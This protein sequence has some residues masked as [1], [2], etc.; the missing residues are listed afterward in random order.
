MFDDIRQELG[1][2]LENIRGRLKPNAD[3]AG[4]TWFRTGG[5]AQ[6]LFQPEDEE[7]LASFLAVLPPQYPVHVIGLGSNL[8]VRDGGIRGVVV[9][10]GAKGFG[11]ATFD[12]ANVTAGTAISDKK[13]AAQALSSG[14]SGFEF[15][16]GIPGAI[17]GALRM[18]AGAHGAETKDIFVSARGVDRQG[19]IHILDK[20]AMGFSYRKTKASPDLIFTSAQF[21]G[22][23]APRA[24]IEEAMV[25][26]QKHREEAQ[27]IKARTGGST[28]KNPPEQSAW[29]IVDSAGCRGLRIGNA[30]V[31]ELHCNFLLNL[32]GASAHDIERLGETVRAKALAATGVRLEW[33]IKRI[34]EFKDGAAIEPFLGET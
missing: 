34:G 22:T 7:D 20:E 26:V 23:L 12:G 15:Y 27:P 13:L 9:R 19:N 5:P 18:N 31:S 2:S 21:K 3:L 8:L 33:E 11:R 10:L 6:L 25:A 28:F 4:T 1:A 32:G 24:E 17:G 14:V 29:K 16:H 30:Q